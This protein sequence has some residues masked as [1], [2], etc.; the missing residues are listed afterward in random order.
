MENSMGE[1]RIG[2]IILSRQI[3]KKAKE[4]LSPTLKYLMDNTPE[5]NFYA[6]DD[7]FELQEV[8]FENPDNYDRLIIRNKAMWV[9]LAEKN[10]VVLLAQYDCFNTM[11]ALSSEDIMDIT[12]EAKEYFVKRNTE[13]NK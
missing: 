2:D 13:S 10:E 8:G 4:L 12:E 6:H 7:G 11:V 3:V 9:H 1:I 5:T